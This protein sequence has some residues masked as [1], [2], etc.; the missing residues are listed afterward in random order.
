MGRKEKTQPLLFQHER[1]SMLMPRPSDVTG[2]F[3][4]LISPSPAS[5]ASLRVAGSVSVS[6]AQFDVGCVVPFLRV[7]VS[8]FFFFFFPKR[9][10][11]CDPSDKRSAGSQ[12]ET[13]TSPAET[14]RNAGCGENRGLCT[15]IARRA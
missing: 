2:P 6:L 7:S 11:K 13:H 15:C 14:A 9:Q 12:Q 3:S 10:T 4:F 1:N 5:D 8:P